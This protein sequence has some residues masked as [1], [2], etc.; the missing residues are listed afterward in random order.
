MGPIAIRVNGAMEHDILH[1][2]EGI[3]DIEE[4]VGAILALD[5]DDQVPVLDPILD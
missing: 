3:H 1:I 2:G 4:K 5:V